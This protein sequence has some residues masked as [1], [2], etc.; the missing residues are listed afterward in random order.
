[1]DQDLAG[2]RRVGGVAAGD[3]QD[4]RAGLA[5]NRGKP[6]IAGRAISH[7]IDGDDDGA[8]VGSARYPLDMPSQLSARVPHT[9]SADARVRSAESAATWRRA[10]EASS[11]LTGAAAEMS[12]GLPP[13]VVADVADHQW[14]SVAAQPA[15]ARR[16]RSACSRAFARRPCTAWPA[17]LRTR[18]LLLLAHPGPHRSS[19]R[20]SCRLTFSAISLDDAVP[21]SARRGASNVARVSIRNTVCKSK[22]PFPRYL[23][24]L[25][26]EDQCAGREGH[27]PA[28]S[29]NVKAGCKRDAKNSKD[30]RGSAILMM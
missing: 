6:G 19:R 27:D 24:R 15:S 3:N 16:R 26:D 25:L 17:P 22:I 13:R 5:G 23:R 11:A 9:R 4:S 1:M 14:W 8:D 18:S 10:A 21:A 12:L 29:R 2:V 28:L 30:P 20:S 7:T